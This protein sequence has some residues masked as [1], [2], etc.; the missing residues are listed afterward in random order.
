MIKKS[1]EDRCHPFHGL[2]LHWYEMCHHEMVTPVPTTSDAGRP[3]GFGDAMHMYYSYSAEN[4]LYSAIILNY[5][6]I[7]PYY[8]FFIS[9]LVR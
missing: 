2:Y 7:H 4:T 9:Y 8:F 5:L 1:S 3:T 6:L